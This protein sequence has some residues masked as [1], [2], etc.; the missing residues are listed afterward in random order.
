MS[1]LVTP[2]PET[3]RTAVPAPPPTAARRRSGQVNPTPCTSCSPCWSIGHPPPQNIGPN[4]RHPIGH[5]QNVE[6]VSTV[7]NRAHGHPVLTRCVPPSAS[8]TMWA[9]S[10][11]PDASAD[12]IWRRM[13]RGRSLGTVPSRYVAA[14][15]PLVTS[16]RCLEAIVLAARIATDH[17]RGHVSGSPTPLMQR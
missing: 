13:R 2:A 17:R 1:D 11:N 4:L 15:T 8:E 16:Y 10:N 14:P 9:T 5:P 3:F 7:M 6:I 12:R